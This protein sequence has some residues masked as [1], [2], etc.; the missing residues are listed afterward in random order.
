MAGQCD[1]VLNQ[2]DTKADCAGKVF[3]TAIVLLGRHLALRTG[4]CKLRYRSPVCALLVSD[5]LLVPA[6][7]HH[8]TKLADESTAALMLVQTTCGDKQS[9]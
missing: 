7:T 4:L 1:T 8:R 2:L 9:H 5:R 6:R 3:L